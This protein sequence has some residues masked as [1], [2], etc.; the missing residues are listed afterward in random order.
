[1]KSLTLSALLLSLA[2]LTACANDS[3]AGRER[4]IDLGTQ[5]RN[6]VVI[7]ASDTAAPHALQ[8]TPSGAPAPTGMGYQAR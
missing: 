3:Q 7:P 4:T 6:T 8:G 2:A 1:M 5:A